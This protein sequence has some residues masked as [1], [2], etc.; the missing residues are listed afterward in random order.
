MR[1]ERTVPRAF[2]LALTACFVLLAEHLPSGPANAWY[3]AGSAHEQHGLNVLAIVP[4]LPGVGERSVYRR[5]D[6]LEHTVFFK[7][8]FERG[9]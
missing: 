9:T 6:T 4:S 1:T 2:G 8:I 7:E 3:E 5:L